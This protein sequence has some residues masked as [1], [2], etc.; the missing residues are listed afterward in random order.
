[1]LLSKLLIHSAIS[2]YCDNDMDDDE[3]DENTLRMCVRIASFNCHG[4]GSRREYVAELVKHYGLAALQEIW[5]FNWD[6]A[7]HPNEGL[8]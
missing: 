8:T 3:N 7:V 2:I 1:M 4:L 5:L 6:L